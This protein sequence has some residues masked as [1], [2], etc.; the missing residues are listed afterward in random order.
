MDTA[1]TIRIQLFGPFQVWREGQRIP[2]KVWKQEKTKRL[3]KILASAPGQVFSRDQLIEWLWPETDPKRAQD[4]L[5]NR[6][7]E[8]RRILEPSL[9]H[10]EQSQFIHTSHEGYYFDATNC[11]IDLQEFRRQCKAGEAAEREGN[12][13][14][15]VSAYEDALRWCEPGEL[16]SEDI[17]EDWAIALRLA[18]EQERLNLL[19]HLADCH[20]RLGHY[21]RAISRCKQL[22]QWKPDQE[23]TLRQ[24]MLY[25]YL[26]G[27]V[28]EA[29]H[30]YE[31]GIKNLGQVSDKT[32]ELY[33]HIQ[34]GHVPGID[35]TY[36][37]PRVI[38]HEIP[39]T[40]S[41]GSIPFVGR[42]KEYAR[43]VDH[44]E[45]A[46]KG[47]GRIVLINGEAGVGKTRLL[48]EL[49]TYA[50]KRFKSIVFQGRCSELGAQLAYQ[51]W[52]EAIRQ[53]LEKLHQEDL[54]AVQPLWLA[55]VAKLIPELRIRMPGLPQNPP[56]PPQQEQMRFF[57]GLVQFF[58]NLVARKSAPKPLVIFL[59][60][61]CWAEP[62][63]LELLSY[64][65]P[66][67]E[68]EPI[69]VLG[70][71][72]PEEVSS[73]HPL[74]HL[75]QTW[76][77]KN[78][79]YIIPLDRLAP[80]EVEAL[81]KK[82]PL[83]VKHLGSFCQ[84]LY[85]ETAG[86]PLFVISTL[87][88][89]FEEGVLLIQGKSWIADVEDISAYYKELMIPQTVKD[90]I[91]RRVARLSELEREL[92]Q[93]ASV[94]GHD[95]EFPLLQQAWG[96]KR[97]CLTV[98][99]SLATA[100][101]ITTRQGRYGFTHDK[102]REVVYND[103][104]LPRK[105]LL[106]QRVLQALEQLYPNL[107]WAELRAQHAYRAADW[108]KALEYGLQALQKAL[109]EHRHQEGLELANLS[110]E[111]SLK[112]ELGGEDLSYVR[113]RRFELL[114]QRIEIY[115][116][117]GRRE[118]QER[119]LD[120]L[121]QLAVQLKDPTKQALALQKRSELYFRMGNSLKA[122]EATRQ[123]WKIYIES[124]NLQGQGEALHS[125]GNIYWSLGRYKEALDYYQQALGIRQGIGDRQGQG[126][127]L[128]NIGIIYSELGEY[129]E[130][131]RYYHQALEIFKEISYPQ[132]Q[133]Y[134]LN[135][136]GNV[137]YHLGHYEEALRYYHQAL[138]V[139]Q[140]IGD[141]RSQA[142]SLISIGLVSHHLGR[143]EEA[144]QYH[145][146]ALEIFQQVGDQRGQAACLTSIGLVFHNLGRYEEALQH[147]Q[148]ALKI[149]Q[150]IGDKQGQGICIDNIG[151]INC[152]LGRYEEALHYHQQALEIFQQ[153]GDRRGQAACLSNIGLV[154]YQ[155]GRFEEAL[156]YY[157][158]SLQIRQEIGD[159]RGQ[160]IC[161]LGIARVYQ[162]QGQY[163]EA[164]ERYHNARGLFEELQAKDL[165]LA[166]LSGEGVV[167]LRLSK[168][169]EAL[170]CST[171]AIQFLE[172]GQAYE[173]PHELY[174]N[175]FKILSAYSRG[176]EAQVYLRKAY[177]IVRQRAESIHDP[178]VRQSFLKNI[179]LHREIMALCSPQG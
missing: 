145:R 76:E 16:L 18:W 173:H 178:L 48:H 56:L 174:F 134:C 129:K 112:L 150:Q 84:Q 106:H 59:D 172:G 43:L 107:E 133:A 34:S 117:L 110:L 21:R 90:L 93:L 140:Q 148:Q 155:G 75:I 50:Q 139:R 30:V 167:S 52:V 85:K 147:Y 87:Q 10:G 49:I 70:T 4:T 94:I 124:G 166:C 128:G 96:H 130:A 177:E 63:S 26:A 80:Q 98:L 86:N 121:E 169:K 157:W 116:M 27:S 118:E 152:A 132:G 77:P 113:H 22:L 14:Q 161:F 159:K 38:R 123:A 46:R 170:T 13:E 20:A 99:E 175:H 32:K 82:L 62:A 7:A 3:L 45:Q 151:L 137:Y 171:Q 168:M 164:L 40:L 97:E 6:I 162:E 71:Y 65:I 54:R 103:M 108:K 125:L 105:Q 36:P 69:L 92:L 19:A 11:F 120:L 68:R 60:D 102:I 156:R 109:Q 67:I 119:D 8:L 66:R 74:I 91:M 5:K 83:A 122:E 44:L 111:A 23:S 126:A 138:Q 141:R 146:P 28:S 61:L 51:P 57:E 131:L 73:K 41:P 104:S 24:L 15:A 142:D 143:Y 153:V 114:T 55:E 101:L 165:L 72:R 127:S 37:A 136:A 12:Y 95:F 176:E 39:Y 29:L 53:G 115:N 1:P 179:K 81:L 100:H 64:L 9:K 163:S 35:K 154:H 89:L 79:L 58:L 42:Q 2:A 88:H 31:E 17:Y 25:H 78:L 135:N 47:H 144:L 33:E 160:G 149:R 158:Q